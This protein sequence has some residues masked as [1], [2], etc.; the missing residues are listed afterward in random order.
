M[1]FICSQYLGSQYSWPPILGSGVCWVFSLH[2][3]F[4]PAGHLQRGDPVINARAID[5]NV[6]WSLL[7][8]LRSSLLTYLGSD[9]ISQHHYSGTFCFG[10]GAVLQDL[11]TKAYIRSNL[12]SFSPDIAAT[13]AQGL[14]YVLGETNSFSCHVRNNRFLVDRRYQL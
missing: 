13:R 11:M 6:R 5:I 7:S 8:C 10:N 14:P 2:V 9:R 4:L 1:D 3:R 12:T